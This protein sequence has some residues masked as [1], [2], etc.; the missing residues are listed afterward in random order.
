M[1]FFMMN[2]VTLNFCCQRYVICHR[3]KLKEPGENVSVAHT[4]LG[5][6][7]RSVQTSFF[8]KEISSDFRVGDEL[9]ISEM[10]IFL[11]IPRPMW[12]A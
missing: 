6:G 3:A 11:E 10:H 8:L 4:H 1:L 7:S 9:K 5:W 2:P 12:S